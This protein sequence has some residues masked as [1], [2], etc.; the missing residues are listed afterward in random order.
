MGPVEG[1]VEQLENDPDQCWRALEGLTRVDADVRLAI[2]DALS[3]QHARPGAVV[4]LRLL[5]AV[6]DPATRAAARSA[7]GSADEPTASAPGAPPGLAMLQD[8]VPSWLHRVDGAAAWAGGAG[9][10]LDETGLRSR[11]YLA[12]PVDGRGIGAIVMSGVFAAQC[13]TAAFL[14]DVRRGIVDVFGEIEPETPARAN[15]IEALYREWGAGCVRDVPELALGLLAG[16]LTL[17]GGLRPGAVREWLIGTVGPGFLPVELPAEV[18]GVEIASIPDDELAGRAHAV[19]D[20]CPSWLDESRL[21]FELAEEISLRE[22]G[23]LVDHERDAGAYRYLFEHRLIHRLEMYRRM[24][25]WM[26]WLWRF[27]GEIELARSALQLAGQLSDEQYAVPSHPFA[28]ALTMRSI[29]RAQS[30][31]G[32]EADPRSHRA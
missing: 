30:R 14:C 26:S 23:P 6:R 13:R 11:R 17:S 4:L 28:L 8:S 15:L 32:T 7:L 2:I 10:A 12:T 22:A 20:A 25:L 5:S 27:S 18:P 31:L 3:R 9:T 16:T 24:L 1:I 19:I 29:E 21:T